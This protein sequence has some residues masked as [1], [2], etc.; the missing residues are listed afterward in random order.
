MAVVTAL[1]IGDGL[2]TAGVMACDATHNAGRVSMRPLDHNFSSNLRGHYRAAVA[3]GASVSVGAG[4]SGIVA[5]FMPPISSS[6]FFIVTKI[7]VTYEVLTAITTATPIDFAAFTYSGA[8][9][10]SA[11][12]GSTT[13]TPTP[14]RASMSPSVIQNATTGGEI[15]A[16]GTGT[17]LTAATGKTNAASAF[18]MGCSQILTNVSATGTAVLVT[19]GNAFIAPL[20]LY[21]CDVANGEHPLVLTGGQGIEI[22]TITAGP[23]S[24]TAKLIFEFT[25]TETSAY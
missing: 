20:D 3:S 25:W 12:S 4:S 23:T 5:N 15:R 16:I 6:L 17:G 2:G 18:A 22:Q 24:G 7:R 8:T 9:A 19:A 1:G 21:K 14:M 13:A 10:V 11:G